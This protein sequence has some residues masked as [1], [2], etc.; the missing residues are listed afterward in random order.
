[1]SRAEVVCVGET[2]AVLSPPDARPL[3]HQTRLAL[4]VGGAESN[5][6]C[7][8]AALGHRSAW[9]GRVGADPLGH[10]VLADLASRDVDVTAA[11]TDPERPTGVYFKDPGPA[12]TG[13]YYYR[14]GSA[15]TA[16][17]RTLARLPAVQE[18]RVLHLTGITPALSAGCADLVQDLVVRR[19]AP[20]PLVSFDVNHRPA[21][22]R[23]PAAPALLALARAA[24]LVFVG[25]DEAETLWGTA[26]PEEIRALLPGPT[27]VVKDAAH[28]ATAYVTGAAPEFVPAPATRVVEQVGAGDAFAAGYLA[29][30]LEN[31]APAEALRLGHLV[32]AAT[33]GT[34]ADVPPP[35]DRTALDPRLALDP[36]AWSALTL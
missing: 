15:A 20:A 31:R 27:L 25:R 5:V 4:T 30:L 36:A 32:A 14:R 3:A 34:R 22:W 26:T 12:G 10:R 28:G 6:A 19:T 7:A 1:M 11:E 18:A 29:A 16:M 8:L 9:L 13:T 35:L 23:T 21:L 2:M 17:D 33:L 24:D